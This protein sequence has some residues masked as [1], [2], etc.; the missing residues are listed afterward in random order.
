MLDYPIIDSHVHLLDPARLGYAWAEGITGLRSKAVPADVFAAA[1]PV[2][3]ERF[4]FVE[5]DVDAGQH[6][7]EAAWVAELAAAEPRLGAMVAS[8][9]LEKGMAVQA[10]LERLRQHKA[11]RGIRR[12]IQ[13]QADP[14]FCLQPGFLAGLKLLARHDLS[15]DICILH[16]QLPNVI[17]MVQQCP[18]VRFVLDHIGKPAIKAGEMEP[19]RADLKR[20][21]ALPNVHCKISG[22]CTEAD[23][24]S[25]TRQEITPYVEHALESFGFERVMFGSDWHVLELAGTYPDWVH[26]VDE[27]VHDCSPSERRKLFRDNAAAFYRLR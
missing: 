17:R 8:L 12:L 2:E 26:V 6:L 9:P 27:I 11:L 20:L 15:F 21:A 13:G 16:H 18:D 25:W 10:D 1:K 7:D 4:V 3:I 24:R 22:V 19:W 5:V 23:H 14:E